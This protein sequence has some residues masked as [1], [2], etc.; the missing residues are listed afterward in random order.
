MTYEEA[1]ALIMATPTTT[2]THPTVDILRQAVENVLGPCR[3][4]RPSYMKVE[5][6][7]THRHPPQFVSREYRWRH[8]RSGTSDVVTAN[9]GPLR[10]AGINSGGQDDHE[11]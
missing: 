8:G 2:A 3:W 9:G 6:N 11:T 7:G 10:Q 5:R 1:E 4:S